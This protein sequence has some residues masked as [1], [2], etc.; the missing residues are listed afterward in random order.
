MLI[1]V[2]YHYI[3]ESFDNPYPG[4]HGMTP[5]Q[6]EAQLKVLGSAAVFVSAEQV[7]NAVRGV[8]EL[9][10]RSILITFDDG[11][12]EQYDV[13]WPIL[14]DLGIPAIFFINT[15]P[16]TDAKVLAVHK[17]HLL[18]AHLPPGD[19]TEMLQRLA[20][21]RGISLAV[22]LDI[23]KAVTQYRYD[24]LEAACLKY[25]LNF[26]LDWVKRDQLIE[27]CF[28]E[29]FPGQ[30]AQISRDLYL[31][32][33]QIKEL[34]HVASI[35]N[36][37]HEHFPLGLL[38]A[39]AMAEQVRLPNRLL[40]SWTGEQPFA[41]SYPYGSEDVCSP[42]VSAVAAQLGIEFA[43]TME[44]AG[45]EDLSHPLHLARFDSNDVPGGK[46]FRGMASEFFDLV[47]TASWCR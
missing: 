12:K 16:I 11:L 14:S 33:S 30:E 19:F 3:R 1:A 47:P 27:D 32:V 46:A 5:A 45:N 41:M 35:G 44:R 7:R 38:S 28:S 4:I 26:E 15:A 13:A 31:D 37:S 2:N 9:P 17:I 42:E 40:E 22:E 8:E 24:T 43:F 39:E 18:R 20:L 29:V 6:F 23:D 21:E 25:L 34:A 10:E 36:H